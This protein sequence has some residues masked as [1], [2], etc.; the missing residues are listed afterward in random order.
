MIRMDADSH[1]GIDPR[2]ELKHRLFWFA[3]ALAVL[4]IAI[5]FRLQEG[6]RPASAA[7]A[8]EAAADPDAPLPRPGRPTHDV[9]AIVNGQDISR[10]DL[11]DECVRRHGEAV[12]ESMVNKKLI[13][14]HCANRGVAVTNE[15]IAAEI[16]RMAK[17]FQLG[18]EQWLELLQKERGVT[19]QEYARDIVWPT[20]ALRKLA[21]KQLQVTPEE[22]TNAYEREFGESVRCRLIAVS[23]A[24]KA[25]RLVADLATNPGNFARVAIENSEDVGSASVGGMVQPI[26]RH[27]GDPAIEQVAFAM[28]PGQISQ[29]IP[30]GTQF[31]ILKCD[32]RIPARP[33]P[34]E[35]VEQRLVD[36]I[37]EEKLRTAAHD[38][39][40]EVQK[41]A[42]IV[43]VY[44]D[45]QLS[46]R[47]PGVVATVNGD[48]ITLQELGAECLLR[49]GEEV[50]EGEISKLLLR[51]TLKGAGLE[52]VQADLDAEI[53]HAAELAGVLD[54]RG[55][56][57]VAK[58]VAT[59]TQEEGVAE[60]LYVADSVWPSAALKKLTESSIK[61]DEADIRKGFE[62]NYGE[63]V[64]CRAIVLGD[65]RRA[66][67]VWE[68]AR[69]NPTVEYFGD[70]AEQYSIEPTSKALRG[71]V[72]PLGRYGGQKQLE[73]AAFQL[74]AGQM[75]G[76][77]QVADKFVVLRCE[78]RTERVRFD[79]NEVRDLLYRDI[80]EK[81]LRIAMSQNYEEIRASSRIDNYLAGTS[82]SP[83]E[84]EP[85]PEA[86]PLAGQPQVRQD[87]AVLPTGGATR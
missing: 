21:D 41:S 87:E 57:D 38:V 81:K 46:E 18:R 40:A 55:E 84:Q 43:N 83:D 78:G 2:A 34:R 77:I 27:M 73:D 47:M 45:P 63:R 85:A 54:Q 25:A 23:D 32:E 17:R 29:A 51:Q 6:P 71:E 59:V 16:D 50:L 76:I 62:A 8:E 49:H 72:P 82:T 30:V 20:I 56:P 42:T 60:E 12:L 68:K 19:P 14:S 80:F 39:F 52:V 74:Q 48:A 79:E 64:R 3:M 10:K 36:K 37:K 86:G 33:V 28:Q 1:Q 11:A 69:K 35:Q 44:N 24:K 75:S 26:R 15:E 65:M 7:P 61:V 66:Q 4:A 22:I 67:E 53:R 13:T 5:L 70:L 9:M 58:W 31:V